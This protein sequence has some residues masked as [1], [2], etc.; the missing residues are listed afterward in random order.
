MVVS[1]GVDKFLVLCSDT[2]AVLGLFALGNRGNELVARLDDGIFAVRSGFGAHSGGVEMS[3]LFCQQI[4]L[5][6]YLH[7]QKR[8]TAPVNYIAQYRVIVTDAAP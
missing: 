1:A 6:G 2:P 8:S 4:Q 3:V 5:A 7:S